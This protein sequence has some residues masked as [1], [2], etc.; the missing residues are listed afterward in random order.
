MGMDRSVV[1]PQGSVPAWSAVR[2]LL[3]SHGLPVEMRMIDGELSF[4]DEEPSAAWRELRLAAGGGMVTVRQES[5]RVLCTTWGNADAQLRQLW[6]ALA[7]AFAE[8]GAGQIDEAG[9]LHSAS[10]FKRQA[11]LPGSFSG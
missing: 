3:Q 7:W 1:F 11:E 6:N 8:A 2:D 5:G 9:A 10:D 4:P